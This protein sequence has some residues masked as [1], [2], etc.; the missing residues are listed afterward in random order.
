MKAYN[1]CGSA[2]LTGTNEEGALLLALD[3]LDQRVEA[4]RK[5]LQ[6]YPNIQGHLTEIGVMIANDF[7][8]VKS[9]LAAMQD[10]PRNTKIITPFIKDPLGLSQRVLDILKALDHRLKHLKSRG[11]S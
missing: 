10:T 2:M 8:M 9:A 6:Q 11:E 7:Q 5:V 3:S 1:F 4:G